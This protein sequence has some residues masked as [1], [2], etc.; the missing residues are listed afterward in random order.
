MAPF[1]DGPLGIDM[2][3]TSERNIHPCVEINLRDTMGRVAIDIQ[4]R[5]ISEDATELEIGFL[6][7]LTSGGIFSPM[8]LLST[9]RDIES[10]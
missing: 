2:L 1:Y 10:N 4:Q 7:R 3:V 8:H 6:R 5:I 9:L